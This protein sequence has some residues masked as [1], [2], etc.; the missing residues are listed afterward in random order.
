M[1]LLD[2]VFGFVTVTAFIFSLYQHFSNKTKRVLEEAKVKAQHQ[3]IQSATYATIATAETADTI[4][5][6][7]KQPSVTE[8]ELRTLARVVRAHL[9]LLVRQ[10]QVEEEHLA[11]WHYGKMIAS[12]LPL[13]R[14]DYSGQV[15]DEAVGPE[16]T[17]PWR[18]DTVAAV[19]GSHALYREAVTLRMLRT[20]ETN[21]VHYVCHSLFAPRTL[22][23]GLIVVVT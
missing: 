15:Q 4:V 22:R 21:A 5:Q 11:N 18:S 12:P 3:R 23:G 7:S 16:G 2:L 20:R 1:D 6:R 17:S 9:V 14:R 19:G 13:Q 8:E 10:L